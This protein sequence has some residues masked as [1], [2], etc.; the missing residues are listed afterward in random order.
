[1]CH[2]RATIAM[3]VRTGGLAYYRGTEVGEDARHRPYDHTM[4]M[5]PGGVVVS[6]RDS[7]YEYL[8]G[9]EE[10]TENV[11]DDCV[12]NYRHLV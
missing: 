10:S 7:L 1:M 4:W 3:Q 6:E 9:L 5:G 8:H 11:R 2:H 12:L